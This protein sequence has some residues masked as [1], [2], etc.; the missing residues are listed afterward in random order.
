MDTSRGFSLTE[1]LISLVLLTGTSLALLKQQM[2][3]HQLFPAYPVAV[4]C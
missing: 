2:Q 1:V 4:Q 3:T